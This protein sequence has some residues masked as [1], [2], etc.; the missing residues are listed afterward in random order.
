MITI[1]LGDVTEYLAHQACLEDS[2]AQ[3]IT[4]DNFANLT[5]GVYYTSLGDIGS[6]WCLGETLMQADKIVYVPPAKWSDE[7]QGHSV[8]KTWYEDYLNIF[9]FRCKI[10]NYSTAPKFSNVAKLFDTRKTEAPQLWIAGC[11]ISHG[12]GVTSETRYGQ[13]LA[14][15]LNLDVSFL[16]TGGS[17]IMWATDQILRSDI[18][19]GD[20]VVWG[21]TT[22][23]RITHFENDKFAFY[24]IRNLRP[25]DQ[26]LE[27]ILSDH[28]TYQC[29]TSVLQ[30]INY[31]KKINAT[32]IIAALLDNEIVNYIQDFDNLI[33]LYGLWG[34]DEDKMFPDIG[35]DGSHPGI[36][37][38]QFYADEIYQKIQQMVAKE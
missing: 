19:S 24:N 21:L 1:Y 30:V 36:A 37:S 10:E 29:V 6:L 7:I 2:S 38:H 20:I 3:L 14:N 28:T 26:L 31:C 18:R 15:R 35:A 22:R 9:K 34:R 4:Q 32:L 11:S 16:T 27:L 33:M 25:R 5:P 17:S 23:N 13:L 12:I 8:M